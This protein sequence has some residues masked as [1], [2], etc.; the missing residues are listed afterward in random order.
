[1]AQP[2]DRKACG[3]GCGGTIPVLQPYPLC[4]SCE[5]KRKEQQRKTDADLAAAMANLGT[6]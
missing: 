2:T 6:K 1:M 3:G 4:A 5:A